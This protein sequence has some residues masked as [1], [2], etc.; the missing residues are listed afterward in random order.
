MFHR[1]NVF[2]YTYALRFQFYKNKENRLYHLIRCFSRRSVPIKLKLGIE[3]DIDTKDLKSDT[4]GM[5]IR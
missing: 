4:C 1:K 3:V 2:R 5:W